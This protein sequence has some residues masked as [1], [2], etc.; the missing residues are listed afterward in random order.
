MRGIFHMPHP[1]LSHVNY[2]LRD[3]SDKPVAET[4]SRR[5]NGTGAQQSSSPR[6]PPPNRPQTRATT[7]AM[8]VPLSPSASS[9]SSSYTR[10]KLHLNVSAQSSPP[11]PQ[12]RVDRSPRLNRSRTLY[13]IGSE[14]LKVSERLLPTSAP[15]SSQSGNSSPAHTRVMRQ[16]ERDCI[17]WAEY[18]D[19]VLIQLENE[20]KEHKGGRY[21]GVSP[22]MVSV[23]RSRCAQIISRALAAGKDVLM[24]S[25]GSKARGTSTRGG[26]QNDEAT[27]HSRKGT[28]FELYQELLPYT[29]EASS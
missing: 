15:S 21:A 11:N 1:V 6:Y 13:T 29:E 27:Y 24:D 26:V 20:L 4:T 28:L 8:H 23:S 7:R 12:P 22:S 5:R 17:E 2:P 9:P 10:P 16:R 14:V 19:G 3:S 18:A 25:S